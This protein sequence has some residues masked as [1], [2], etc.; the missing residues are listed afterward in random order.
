MEQHPLEYLSTAA[1]VRPFVPDES[2]LM[3]FT[4]TASYLAMW[5]RSL[6]RSSHSSLNDASTSGSSSMGFNPSNK[7]LPVVAHED[8]Q[9][10]KSHRH[11]SHSVKKRGLRRLRFGPALPTVC[12]AFPLDP[13]IPPHDIF[14]YPETSSVKDYQ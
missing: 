12:F 1:P 10:M 8:N 4:V 14:I 13:E 7:N 11:P 5:S 6:T 9:T 3:S 2:A